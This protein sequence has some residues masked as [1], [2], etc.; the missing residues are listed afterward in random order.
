MFAS[1]NSRRKVPAAHS[2]WVPLKRT[3]NTGRAE[4]PTAVPA[5]HVEQQQKQQQQQQQQQP[6]DYSQK[7]VE[8]LRVT[9]RNDNASNLPAW[10]I[11]QQQQN[12]ATSS[13]RISPSMDHSP[14]TGHLV[15]SVTD[16]GSGPAPRMIFGGSLPTMGMERSGASAAAAV[17]VAETA[18]DGGDN[19]DEAEKLR[20]AL[21]EQVMKKKK[22]KIL[23]QPVITLEEGELSSV[24][25]DGQADDDQDVA[26][27]NSRMADRY[28]RICINET[29]RSR[30]Q[31]NFKRRR[32]SSISSDSDVIILNEDGPKTPQKRRE[33]SVEDNSRKLNLGK[34]LKQEVDGFLGLD[35][36]TAEDWEQM[37]EAERKRLKNAERKLR[38][39]ESYRDNAK[40]NRDKFLAKADRCARQIGTTEAEMEVLMCDIEKS[41]GRLSFLEREFEKS[42]FEEGLKKA[43]ERE[44]RK[45]SII[46]NEID[47]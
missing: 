26:R 27:R 29:E 33:N 25:S 2:K 39:R 19:E 21:L 32:S 28:P 16:S 36:R 30:Q 12:A 37:V 18:P 46:K 9:V 14:C 1:R 6:T 8:P 3:Q 10:M 47:V 4:Y 23:P 11:E 31:M 35:E 13:S 24:N 45:Q 5:Q 42:R 15:F 17:A 20:A 38:H 41:K 44:K 40:R 43:A 34:R 7:Y 22:A